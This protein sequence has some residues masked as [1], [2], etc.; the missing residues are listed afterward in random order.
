MRE[1]KLRDDGLITHRFRFDEYKRAVATS[2][3]KA[4]AQSIKVVFDYR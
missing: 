2:L 1:G 3:N 4:G